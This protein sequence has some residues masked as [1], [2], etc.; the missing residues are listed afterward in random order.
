[1][2]KFKRK[3]RRLKVN[4]INRYLLVK[5]GKNSIYLVDNVCSYFFLIFVLTTLQASDVGTTQAELSS[6]L[7]CVT[8]T[9]SVSDY[10][11]ISE[12]AYPLAVLLLLQIVTDC[13]VTL[14]KCNRSF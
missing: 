1:V 6:V 11:W 3:F 8:M 14:N 7:G 10:V 4:R 2:L 5:I 12:N 13:D 9:F